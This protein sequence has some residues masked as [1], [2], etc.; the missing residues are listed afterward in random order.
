[1]SLIIAIIELV[2]GARFLTEAVYMYIREF[3]QPALLT[4]PPM[5]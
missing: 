2:N 4:I 5:Q 1:M 3:G